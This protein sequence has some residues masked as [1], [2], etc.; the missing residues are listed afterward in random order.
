MKLERQELVRLQ[1]QIRALERK[2]GTRSADDDADGDESGPALLCPVCALRAQRTLHDSPTHN[3]RSACSRLR[4]R[5]WGAS[6]LG[7][8]MPSCLPEA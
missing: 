2:L 4:Q 6:R 3:S 1:A 7:P 5:A 8:F